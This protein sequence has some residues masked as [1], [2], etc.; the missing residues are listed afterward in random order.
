M[1]KIYYFT[2]KIKSR[3]NNFTDKL[4]NKEEDENML[5]NRRD[6]FKR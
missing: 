2:D 6:I 5:M 4:V 1:D 3:F